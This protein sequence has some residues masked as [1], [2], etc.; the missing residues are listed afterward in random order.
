MQLVEGAQE[1]RGLRCAAVG[2]Q[3]VGQVGAHVEQAGLRD[4]LAGAERPQAS[5]RP[6]LGDRPHQRDTGPGRLVGALSRGR[7]LLLPQL[8]GVLQGAGGLR[9]GQCGPAGHV[10]GADR[11][12]ADGVAVG[13]VR[14]GGTVAIPAVG[15]ACAGGPGVDVRQVARVHD[16]VLVA[17]PR[18][19]DE[20]PL[21]LKAHQEVAAPVGRDVLTAEDLHEAGLLPGRQQHRARQRALV[22]DEAQ[23]HLG[24]ALAQSGID[25]VVGLA[26]P[27]PGVGAVHEGGPQ[28]VVVGGSGDVDSAA[29]GP[30]ANQVASRE[31]GLDVDR[32]GLRGTHEQGVGDGGDLLSLDGELAADCRDDVGRGGGRDEALGDDAGQA[33]LGRQ[34]CGG[35]AGGWHGGLLRTGGS[36]GRPCRAWR[37]SRG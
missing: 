13:D 17:G 16:E 6:A 10:L 15:D 27:D 19:L 24:G 29:H 36:S 33:H 30:G 5:A 35:C 37:R 25:A 20:D 21:A 31:G 28:P 26:A 22:L 2:G 9:L 18:P 23:G 11:A 32:S 7:G 8:D 12:V 3:E 14:A 34:R 4:R 1:V